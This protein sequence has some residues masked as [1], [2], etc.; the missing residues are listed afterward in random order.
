MCYSTT[1]GI[2]Q[3]SLE[4]SPRGSIPEK[5]VKN[6]QMQGRRSRG[7]RFQVSAPNPTSAQDKAEQFIPAD[8]AEGA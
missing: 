7:V 2:R 6:V 1:D 5:V 8:W 4:E 3:E